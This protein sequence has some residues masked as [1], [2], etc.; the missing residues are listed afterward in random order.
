MDSSNRGRVVILA[1]GMGKRLA[2][3]TFVIPK[4]IVPIGTT[5]SIEV[6]LRQL[7]R[8]GFLDITIAVGHMSDIIRAVA[9]DGSKFGVTIS[10]SQ[11]TKP[12]GTIGPLTLIDGLTDDFLVMNA[13]L[14]TDLDFADLWSFHRSHGGAATVATYVKTT[15]LELGV[16]QLDEQER[17][18]GFE[19]KPTLRHTVS[20][21][22][23]VFNPTRARRYPTEHVLRIRFVDAE[24][25]GQGRTGS[26]L[27][28]WR[29]VAGHWRAGRLRK[30]PG[31]IRHAT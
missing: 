14:L 6:V 29:T 28:F 4:P 26:R 16:L 25:A 21:G 8:R 23:Y 31:G 22:I 13:D 18:V 12:L 30:G 7:A 9:G 24:S 17:L 11:E 2:P 3:Y 5:P 19:E 15:K 10:Y 27:S 1:G 20:M